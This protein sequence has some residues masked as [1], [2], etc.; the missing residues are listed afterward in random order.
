MNTKV[1]ALTCVYNGL[2]YL[3]DAIES[4]L[5]QSYKDFEYLIIDDASPDENVIKLI[6]SYHDPR[7]RLVRNKKNLGVSNTINKALSLIKTKYVVRIDQDD[8]N[9]PNRIEQQIDYLEK[10][11]TIDIVCSWEKTIDSS[12]NKIRNW[13]RTLDNY[14]SFLGYVLIGIC[15]IWHPSIA[16]KTKVMIEAGGFDES[17]L[18]AEDFEV[19]SRLALQRYNAAVVPKFHLLQRQHNS[20]QSSEFI[21]IQ[22]SVSRRI[23]F[24]AISKFSSHSDIQLLADFLRLELNEKNIKITKILLIKIYAVMTDLIHNISTNQNLS[25][26]E[27][28]SLQK[29]IYSRV[30]FGVKFAPI[31]TR[32]P[33][34]L[35]YLAFYILS[36][37]QLRNL[38]MWLS[39]SYHRL[40]KVRYLFKFK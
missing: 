4:T 7:I 25:E 32:L 1:T 3:K 30:G 9:L 26:N 37:L 29:I 13:K 6:E 10:N 12:G 35:F 33:S 2:P 17:Y 19:T 40:L 21:D 34:F 27:L 20:S 31:I 16:F 15:P 14:G 28:G 24:E 11:P 38:R 23:H 22:A 5:S 36:P 39:K 8:I 18:R